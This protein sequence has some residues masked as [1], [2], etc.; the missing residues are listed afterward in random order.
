M[1][2]FNGYSPHPFFGHWY[3]EAQ[4]SHPA[5]RRFVKGRREDYAAVQAGLT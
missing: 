1:F 4:L 2:L 5:P 3:F